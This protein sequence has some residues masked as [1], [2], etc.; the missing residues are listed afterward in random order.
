MTASVHS[1]SHRLNLLA[2]LILSLAACGGDKSVEPEESLPTLS[3]TPTTPSVEAR[4]GAGVQATVSVLQSDGLTG[5]V[6][7]LVENAPV[8]V[9]SSVAPLTSETSARLYRVTF[10]VTTSATPG[11]HAVRIRAER[12][13]ATAGITTISLSIPEAAFIVTPTTMRIWQ[14]GVGSASFRYFRPNGYR[15]NIA[16]SVEPLPSGITATVSPQILTGTDETAVVTFVSDG[17][18]PTGN[19]SAFVRADAPGLMPLNR[20]VALTIAAPFNL[21]ASGVAV[22]VT[23]G[24][25]GTGTVSETRDAEFIEAVTLTVS[26][27]PPGVTVAI[28]PSPTN[29]LIRSL[30]FTV[31]TDS[32]VGQYTITITGV[33]G[34]TVP[35]TRTVSLPLVIQ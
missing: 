4:R 26:G 2:A 29:V 3:I 34:G 16:L 19:Y 24:G 18:R 25:E 22:F 28:V 14:T 13:G 33:S 23:R 1:V 35:I 6:T 5:A 30:R 12:T 17:S 31:A 7:V 15:E 9:T 20:G 21:V 8:G 10:I 32:P 27:L 11:T